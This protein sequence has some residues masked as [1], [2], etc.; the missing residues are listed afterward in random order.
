MKILLDT[1]VL[2]WAQQDS[3]RLGKEARQC[4]ISLSNE[5]WVS[6]ISSLEVAR[7]VYG[8]RLELGKTTQDWIQKSIQ[9][10]GAKSCFVDH[11]VAIE[12]YLLPEP[13]HPDPADR[14]LVATAR[15][16]EMTLMT[17]DERILAYHAVH[18][19]DAGT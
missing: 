15:L 1:H 12:S 6:S 8:N 9:S 16:H 3:P 4:L 17:A 10:L 11:S 2:I 14:L 19:I 5:L 13:F 18:T 7:L